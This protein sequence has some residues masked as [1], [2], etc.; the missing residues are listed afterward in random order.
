MGQNCMRDANFK[1]Y[2]LGSNVIFNIWD[3]LTKDMGIPMLEIF[4]VVT[5]VWVRISNLNCEVIP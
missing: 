5:K 2:K 4:L 3:G 1:R